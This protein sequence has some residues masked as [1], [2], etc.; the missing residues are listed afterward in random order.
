MK[1][2]SNVYNCSVIELNKIHDRTG[3]ITVIEKN[4][5]PFHT[6]RIYYLYDVPGGSERG[7]HAHYEMQHLIIAVTGSFE[8]LLNDGKLKKIVML[9]R[10]NFGLYIPPL[11]WVELLNFSSGA[12]CLNLVSTKYNETDYIRNYQDF[13]AITERATT[14]PE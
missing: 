11:I 4:E 8:V 3:N 10:P 1:A 13:C 7:G 5:L 12:I 6:E 9:N 2:Y 14:R